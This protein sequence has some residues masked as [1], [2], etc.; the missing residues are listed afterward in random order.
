M[1]YALAMLV[2]LAIGV[3]TAVPVVRAEVDGPSI[4]HYRDGTVLHLSGS[5]CSQHPFWTREY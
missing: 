4:C 3:V 1:R 2:A 5:P